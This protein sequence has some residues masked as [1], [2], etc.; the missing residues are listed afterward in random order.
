ML[1]RFALVSNHL[2]FIHSSVCRVIVDIGIHPTILPI[3]MKVSPNESKEE[4]RHAELIRHNQQHFDKESTNWDDPEYV[5]V[6]HETYATLI[7][8]MKFIISRDRTKVLN[9]GCGTGL[10]ESQLRHDV[11]E[12]VGIDIS[13]GMIDRMQHKIDNEKWQNVKSFQ[14]DIGRK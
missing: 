13:A 4:T 8:H 3:I 14:L 2:P 10:L 11:K 5:R 12:C 1:A 9:F 7:K 6:S